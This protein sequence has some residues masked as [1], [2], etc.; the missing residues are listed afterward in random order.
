MKIETLYVL[1]IICLTLLLTMIFGPVYLLMTL[2]FSAGWIA[3]VFWIT[4]N[5]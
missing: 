5:E 1:I 3:C 2:S 4:R